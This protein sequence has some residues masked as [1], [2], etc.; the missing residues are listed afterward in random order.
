M[1]GIILFFEKEVTLCDFM[2]R[3]IGNA[4]KSHRYTVECVLPVN[5]FNQQI[6]QLVWFWYIIVLTTNIIGLVVWLLRM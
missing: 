1:L 4:K 2:I 6:F 3:E 5:L